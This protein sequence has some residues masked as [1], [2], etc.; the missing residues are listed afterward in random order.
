MTP[1][2]VGQGSC[3]SLLSP[4]HSSIN[5]QA[6]GRDT[7]SAFLP[8]ASKVRAWPSLCLAPTASFSLFKDKMVR[9]THKKLRSPFP[10]LVS[11]VLDDWQHFR[12]VLDFKAQQLA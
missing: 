8:P 5:Y 9:T 4:V 7:P 1:D 10:L 12:P 3:C 6:H 2:K 11:P